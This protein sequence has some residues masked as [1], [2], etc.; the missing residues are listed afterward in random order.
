MSHKYT[1]KIDSRELKIIDIVLSDPRFSATDTLELTKVKYTIETHK[2]GDFIVHDTT[3]NETT[4]IIER[5]TASDLSSSIIDGR[6]RE[7]KDRLVDACGGPENAGHIVFII[8]DFSKLQHTSL[9]KTTLKSAIQNMVLKHGFKVL[10]T[11]SVRD[12]LDTLY[13]IVTKL[14][15]GDTIPSKSIA[16][17]P[18]C[19]QANV[20]KYVLAVQLSVIQGVS[21]QTGIKIQSEYVCM[22]T[23]VDAFAE[24]GQDLLSTIQLGK[25][26]LGSVL[27]RRIYRFLFVATE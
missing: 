11:E 14:Q 19:K 20:D 10:Y 22:K 25:R 16:T 4:Y 24:H 27:S 26:K 7:Q 17:H 13:S 8:E 6:F 1:L 23:L 18:N 2:V 5:K 21:L 12:T 3:D 9:P 15:C